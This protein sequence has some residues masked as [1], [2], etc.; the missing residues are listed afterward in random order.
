MRRERIGPDRCTARRSAL[1]Q[2]GD[3]ADFARYIAP[4]LGV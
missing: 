2:A 3:E 1:K 4:A